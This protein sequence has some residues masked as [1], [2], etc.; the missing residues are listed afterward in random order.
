[1]SYVVN[2]A[3]GD[4]ERFRRAQEQFSMGNYASAIGELE[5]LIA[6]SDAVHSLSDARLLLARAYFASAQLSRAETMARDLV[7]ANP[8][9]GYAVLLLGRT[10]QRQGRHAEGDALL[11]RARAL[12]AEMPPAGEA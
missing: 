11:D 12:G 3:L 8:S 5:Y 10:L 7:D 2:P 4:Y 9:D 1:M 6:N